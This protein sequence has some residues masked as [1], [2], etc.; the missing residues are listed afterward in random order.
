[1]HAVGEVNVDAP[2]GLEHGGVAR[3]ASPEGVG[4][5]VLLAGD[6]ELPQGDRYEPREPVGP[7][8]SIT[9]TPEGQDSIEI[10]VIRWEPPHVQADRVSY[11]GVELTFT[12]SFMPAQTQGKS[13]V[14]TRLDIDG[15]GADD[16]GPTIGPGIAEDFPQAL[17]S[18]VEAARVDM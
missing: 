5:R 17:D 4:A 12:H 7:G 14:T 8:A 16:V 11:G 6:I 9:M 2:A 18:L 10:T 13:V 3:R 15:P 1:M